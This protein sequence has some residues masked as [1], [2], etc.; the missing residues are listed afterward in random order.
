MAS[1][2]K[3]FK[4]LKV[5]LP[6]RMREMLIPSDEGF[7]DT[8]YRYPA[9]GSQTPP[10]ITNKQFVKTRPLTRV[11]KFLKKRG[12]VLSLRKQPTLDAP[13]ENLT[14]EEKAEKLF[15]ETE[16]YPLTAPRIKDNKVFFHNIKAME[17]FDIRNVRS[18]NKNISKIE[19][20]FGVPIDRKVLRFEESEVDTDEPL[21]KSTNNLF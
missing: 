8:N 16:P 4:K 5:F 17:G 12:E 7:F 15:Y 10:D 6:K 3:E 14:A 1:L 2:I 18:I 11:Y 21:P 9:P 13:T 20:E 19:N